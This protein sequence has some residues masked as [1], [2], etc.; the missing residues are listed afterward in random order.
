MPEKSKKYLYRIIGIVVAALLIYAPWGLHLRPGDRSIIRGGMSIVFAV[1]IVLGLAWNI[2]ALKGQLPEKLFGGKDRPA[3][4]PG[5]VTEAVLSRL[6]GSEETK[7]TLT[8]SR[9]KVFTGSIAGKAL[10]QGRTAVRKAE[11]FRRI[12]A[13]KFGEQ[14]LTYARYAGTI[15]QCIET[16][17]KNTDALAWQMRAFDEEE[18]ISLSGS[19]A[20]GAYEKDGI[21]DNV[22]ARR[23]LALSGQLDDMRGI[24][25]LNEKL[26]LHLDTCAREVA[27]LQTAENDAENEMILEEIQRLIETTKYYETKTRK[28]CPSAGRTDT[29]IREEKTDGIQS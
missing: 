22:Q 10:E 15:D 8:E 4:A 27:A 2:R 20:G 14:S 11:Q 16:I 13:R 6:P 19:I 25:D 23:L 24:L 26:V 3:P 9:G 21:D 12:I 29:V 7:K 28:P 5:P 17:G 18:Y 1:L